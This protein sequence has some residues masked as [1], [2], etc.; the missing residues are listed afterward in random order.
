VTT[1]ASAR[2]AFEILQDSGADVLVSDIAMPGEDGY[3]LM[4]RIRRASRV[5]SIPAVAVTAYAG[6]EDREAALRAGYHAHVAK[7]VEP[8]ALAREVARIA[9]RA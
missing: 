4:E 5:A 8:A 7:P 3:R 2:Q 9:G 6:P 1:A